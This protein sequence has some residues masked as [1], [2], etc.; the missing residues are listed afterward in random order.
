[1]NTAITGKNY[2]DQF[3]TGLTALISRGLENLFAP[4]VNTGALAKP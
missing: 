3:I 1:M 4:G 2:P